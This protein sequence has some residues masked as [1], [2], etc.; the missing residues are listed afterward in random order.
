MKHISL[1]FPRSLH[2]RSKLQPYPLAPTAPE[3]PTS[4]LSSALSNHFN[5]PMPHHRI[6]EIRVFPL[7]A[8]RKC[9]I[10]PRCIR[11]R[12]PYIGYMFLLLDPL[13]PCHLF[14]SGFLGPHPQLRPWWPKLP[15]HFR[16]DDLNFPFGTRDQPVH[17]VGVDRSAGAEG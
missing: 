9:L 17:A 1:F 6:L 15:L 16:R 10:H 4:R 14:Q 12:K 3:T 5:H 2:T 7:L 8:R 11:A 13:L